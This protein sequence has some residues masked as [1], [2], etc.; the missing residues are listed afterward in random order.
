MSIHPVMLISILRDCWQTIITISAG[1]TRNSPF[2]RNDWQVAIE[3]TSS[4]V[5]QIIVRGGKNRL[6]EYVLCLAA[7]VSVTVY[8]VPNI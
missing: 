3:M 1:Q 4:S 7:F 5:L 2:D 6:L 8:F